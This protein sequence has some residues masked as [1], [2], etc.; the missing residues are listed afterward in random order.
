V[1]ARPCQAAR[2]DREK[3]K[4]FQWTSSQTDVGCLKTNQQG[5][6]EMARQ[7]GLE[8]WGD[9]GC[10]TRPDHGKA[11]RMTAPIITPSA[12]R[13]V[14]ESVYYKPTEFRFQIDK[15]YILNPV[16]YIALRRNEVKEK[17]AY[18]RPID[19]T[20]SELGPKGR[21]Q[22]QSICLWK[23]RYKI[24]ATI[25]PYDGRSPDPLYEQFRSRAESGQCFQ[26]PCMG[27]REF[28]AFFEWSDPEVVPVAKEE[29][30]MDC[31]LLLY[32]VFDLR[33][34]SDKKVAVSPSFFHA[35]IVKNL[36]EVPPYESKLVMKVNE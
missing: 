31:G 8:I 32:D 24:V 30:N 28:V 15:I 12:A 9:L 20:V 5:G 21:T 1:K 26:R 17:G 34:R 10:F 11:E 4:D 27:C 29:I 19:P 18:G 36:L 35:K 33:V 7:V 2:K 16:N 25:N 22:R 3:E 14:S 13:G 23:P 6:R